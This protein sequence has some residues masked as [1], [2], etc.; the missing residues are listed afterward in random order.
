MGSLLRS[1]SS[2]KKETNFSK[3]LTHAKGGDAGNMVQMLPGDGAFRMEAAYDVKAFQD[4]VL[5]EMD[6]VFDSLEWTDEEKGNMRKWIE[7]YMQIYVSGFAGSMFGDSDVFL[8]G[9]FIYNVEDPERSLQLFREMT[10]NLESFG[11]LD[12]YK[13][14]GME[15]KFDYKENFNEHKGIPIHRMEMSF[16][17]EEMKEKEAEPFLK[18]F[19]NLNYDLAIVK[20]Y[21]VYTIGGSPIEEVI[22]RVLEGGPPDTPPLISKEQF[23]EG[24]SFYLDLGLEGYLRMISNIMKDIPDGTEKEKT[25]DARAKIDAGLT[26]LS[27]APPISVG[28]FADTDQAS[29]KISVPTELL[30]KGSQA[31]GE[32]MMPKG[33]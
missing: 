7:E 33:D 29:L 12:R 20:G 2:P 31:V 26:A 30:Q 16:D 10:T 3:L 14:M 19:T 24:G 9:S 17:F 6:A 8:N 27:G 23:G 32:V 4:F 13:K 22:D 5:D 1:H 28:L 21:L 15:M 25:E 11:I 18:A